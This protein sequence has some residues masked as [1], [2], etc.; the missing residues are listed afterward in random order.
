MKPLYTFLALFITI[1]VCAQIGIG[2]TFP[3]G[4]LDIQSTTNGVVIPRIALT[5]RIVSAPVV[6]PQG[7]ALSNGTLIWNTATA[8]TSPNNVVPGFYFWNGGSWNV[9]AGVPTR[10]WAVGGNAITDPTTEFIGTTTNQD[11]R[12]RTN[13]NERFTFTNNGLLRSHSDGTAPLPVYSWNVD[14]DTGMYRIT[15][16]TFGF[17]T[18]GVERMRFLASGQVSVN[19]IAP[20]SGD[21]FT[22]STSGTNNYAINGFN[23]LATGSAIYALNSNTANGYSTIEGVSNAVDAAGVYGINMASA[24]G[25]RVGVRGIANSGTYNRQ[26]GIQGSYDSNAWGIGIIGIAFGGGVPAGNNDVAIMGW[27]QNNSDFSGYFNGNHAVVNGTKSASVGTSQG[28]QLL[29]VTESP[30]VWFED[31]GRSKLIAGSVTIKL[32]PLFLETIFID[33]NHPISVF[34]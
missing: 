20:S 26:I 34:L 28:N 19:N 8:G 31:V 2:T 32:D 25:I 21:L 30:E 18:A 13:G 10:D 6:N 24:P 16:N 33:D 23:T 4:A 22:S 29:Y 15:A 1:S 7:G 14:P 27:R 9:I 11:F 17:S 5:S 12:V 3:T